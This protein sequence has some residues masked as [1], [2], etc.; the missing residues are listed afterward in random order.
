LID[1]D[2]SDIDP[3]RMIPCLQCRRHIKAS[4]SSCPF[5][6]EIQRS[7][8]QSMSMIGAIALAN[9]MAMTGCSGDETSAD[10]EAGTTSVGST[11]AGSTDAGS[12]DEDSTTTDSSSESEVTDSEVTDDDD[13]VDTL[14][15]QGLSFYAGPSGD[16]GD[17]SKCDPF[18][19][20]CP[21][22][23][24]CVPFSNNGGNLN[25]N[26]C[27]PVLGEGHVGDPCISD[28]AVEATDDCDAKSVCHDLMEVDGQLVGE[29]AAFCTGNADEPTCD[30]GTACLI[31]GDGSVTLCIDTCDPLAQ[32]CD[33]G[34]GCY[35]STVDF[36]C[37]FTTQDIPTGEACGYVNDCASGNYCADGSEVPGCEAP[38]CCTS[39]CDLSQPTCML[40][41]SECVAFFDEG[42][43]PAGHENLG[44]CLI[45]A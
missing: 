44:I 28:G 4:E 17:V 45:P 16:F 37:L 8:G 12:T 30:P 10:D 6:G 21:E 23:E 20:D 15:D 25:A 2:P 40:P 18:A 24:K 36:V 31:Q 19:Q 34:F 7:I 26:K 38:A 22:G 32:N 14:E 35:W 13:S 5:C 27:V 43:A 11:D 1:S 33:P 29:C 41:G 42:M 3:E 39:Y 9:L